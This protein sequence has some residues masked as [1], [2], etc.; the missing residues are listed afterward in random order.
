MS[1][2]EKYIVRKIIDAGNG[3]LKEDKPLEDGSFFVLRR[4]DMLASAALWAYVN[5]IR[6][7]IEV[8][9]LFNS[10]RSLEL[11]ASA[12]KTAQL[13]MVWETETATKKLPD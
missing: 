13:A 6:T 5:T 4:Q 12:D 2:P 7:A 1:L 10:N 3:Q 9:N 11:E 8:L